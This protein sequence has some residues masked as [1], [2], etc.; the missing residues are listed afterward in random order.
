[1]FASRFHGHDERIDIESLGLST[2]CWLGIGR[3][4]SL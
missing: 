4:L 3:D 2:D 1:L